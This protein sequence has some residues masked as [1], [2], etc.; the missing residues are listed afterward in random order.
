MLKKELEG[1]LL[2]KHHFLLIG[3]GQSPR[4]LLVT[5]EMYTRYLYFSFLKCR[6]A[7]DREEQIA[8]TDRQEV[9]QNP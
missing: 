6:Q 3:K 1:S 4:L 5:Y 7:A 2:G 8:T 9:N